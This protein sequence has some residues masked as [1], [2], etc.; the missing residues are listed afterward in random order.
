MIAACRIPL[1]LSNLTCWKIAD[2]AWCLAAGEDH[3]HQGIKSLL[4]EACEGHRICRNEL[5]LRRWLLAI[6]CHGRPLLAITSAGHLV[7]PGAGPLWSAADLNEPRL[8]AIAIPEALPYQIAAAVA[9]IGRRIA[10]SPPVCPM[11]AIA[12]PPA[13]APSD[14]M[15]VVST[16]RGCSGRRY[17]ADRNNRKQ[18]QPRFAHHRSPYVNRG[19]TT[20]SINMVKAA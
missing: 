7:A 16:A 20:V 19:M 18:D 9:I 12:S 2:A 6:L 8:P 13:A 15:T 11:P 10:V 17:R 5:V 4:C 1:P 3:P 14:G